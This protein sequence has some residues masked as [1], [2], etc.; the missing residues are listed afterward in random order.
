MRTFFEAA[1][2]LSRLMLGLSASVIRYFDLLTY[3]LLPLVRYLQ[4]GKEAVEA[5]DIP[6]VVTCFH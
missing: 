6:V 2:S 3:S 5:E 1:R 4:S